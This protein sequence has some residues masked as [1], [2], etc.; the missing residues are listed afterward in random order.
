MLRVTDE[1]LEVI[2]LF[3]AKRLRWRDAFYAYSSESDA[4]RSQG[5]V[6]EAAINLVTSAVGL[7][8][9]HSKRSAPSFL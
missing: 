4:S 1:G 2:T 9:R 7:L 8:M 5:L 6:V 3:G